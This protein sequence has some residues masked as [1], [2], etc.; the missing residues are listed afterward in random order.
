MLEKARTG[1]MPEQQEQ[2]RRRRGRSRRR[3]PTGSSTS[4]RSTSTAGRATGRAGPTDS[5]AA[6]PASS[7]APNAAA[8][9]GRSAGP[10]GQS[11]RQDFVVIDRL[12][13][14]RHAGAWR[15]PYPRSP[16]CVPAA[17]P[18]ALRR[19]D[20]RQR[21]QQVPHD[22]DRREWRG[23]A[24]GQRRKCSSSIH[25]KQTPC[26]RWGSS[27]PAISARSAWSAQVVGDQCRVRPS[28]RLGTPR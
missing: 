3:S 16:R 15:S 26:G 10:R 6:S 28:T 7:P 1:S 13:S 19:R 20:P 5:R 11:A 25:V 17:S 21:Q 8:A 9:G 4:S 12:A 18:A 2:H 22:P 24:A 23:V 14:P 27:S